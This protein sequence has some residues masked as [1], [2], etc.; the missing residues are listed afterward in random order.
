MLFSQL[1]VIDALIHEPA[2]QRLLR[3]V[4]YVVRCRRVQRYRLGQ[5]WRN[6]ITHFSFLISYFENRH[7]VGGQR[8][9]LVGTNHRH[10]TH[11]L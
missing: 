5:F 10:G 3:G 7:A 4:S 6:V 8:S 9:R 11:G 1:L 2:Q